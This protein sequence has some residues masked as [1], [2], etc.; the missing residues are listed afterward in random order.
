MQ[1]LKITKKNSG[2]ILVVDDSEVAELTATEMLS[3][4]ES[5]REFV[6]ENAGDFDRT[7]KRKIGINQKEFFVAVTGFLPFWESLER[8][9]WEPETFDIFDKFIRPDS[10]FLDIGG[11][12][13]S[14]ALYGAQLAAKTYV[15]EPDPIAFAELEQNV[16]LNRETAWHGRIQLQNVAIAGHNGELEIGAHGDGGDSMSSALLA[17]KGDSW[18]VK[19]F[20]L[21][22]FLK[23]ENLESESLFCKMDIEG[24]EY[25]LADSI[26]EF[27]ARCPQAHIFLSLHPQFLIREIDS[28]RKGFMAKRLAFYRRHKMLFSAF[29]NRKLEHVNGKPFKLEKELIKALVT[30]DFPKGVVVLP[31]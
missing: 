20:E 23:S 2:G 5:M 24:F 13:G 7:P 3:M 30:G 11:W 16:A 17:E 26:A 31:V 12:I 18:T 25:D 10:V 19:S 8:K 4:A 6:I 9:D 15:F 28:T 21:V 1:K 29:K 27:A 14:T 22:S